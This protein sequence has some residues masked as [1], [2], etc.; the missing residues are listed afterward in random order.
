MLFPDP[1]TIGVFWES[2]NVD[3]CD[4]RYAVQSVTFSMISYYYNDP[5]SCYSP[6][7]PS[8]QPPSYTPKI[9]DSPSS[10]VT[11]LLSCPPLSSSYWCLK[12]YATVCGGMGVLLTS[13]WVV[14][15]TYVLYQTED[16]DLGIQRF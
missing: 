10:N 14:G 8:I 4:K 5:R 16:K 11:I 3:D 6:P 13:L 2:D 9:S 15:H 7:H 1:G 12:L